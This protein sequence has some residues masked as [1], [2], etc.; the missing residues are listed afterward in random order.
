MKRKKLFGKLNNK[1]AGVVAVIVAIAL[2]S[3][4]ASVVLTTSYSNFKI[5]QTNYKSKTS[6]YS[7]ETALDEIAIGLQ[8]FVSE[9]LSYSYRE[10]I[11]NFNVLDSDQKQEKMESLYYSKLWEFLDPGNLNNHKKYDVSVL[12]GFLSEEYDTTNQVGAVVSSTNPEMITYDKKGI[13]LKNVDVYY[14]DKDDYSTFLSTDIRL[15]YPEVSFGVARDIPDI[16]SYAMVADTAV[17]FEGPSSGLTS[18]SKIIGQIYAGEMNTNV[19]TNKKV[20]LLFE[21]GNE[22]NEEFTVVS[23]N[24]INLVNSSVEFPADG[25]LW[26]KSIV[27]ASSEVTLRGTTNLSDDLE[28]RGNQSKAVVYGTYNGYGNSTEKADESSAIIINGKHSV[29]DFSNTDRVEL[30]GH[31][32]IGTSGRN[33]DESLDAKDVLTGESIAVKSDQLIY[34]VPSGAIGTNSSGEPVYGKNPMT[35]EEYLAMLGNAVITEVNFDYKLTEDGSIKLSDFVTTTGTNVADKVIKVFVPIKSNGESKN[36]VYYYI[37]FENDVKANEY[38][39]LLSDQDNAL[40]SK[41]T[42]RYADS[43][44]VADSESTKFS[45]GYYYDF[46][47]GKIAEVKAPLTGGSEH[48]HFD[49]NKENYSKKKQALCTKLVTNS[50]YLTEEELKN[51]LTNDVVFENLVDV[52]KVDSKLLNGVSKFYFKDD[53]GKNRVLFTNEAEYTY[54][55]TGIDKDLVIIISKGNVTVNNDF[56]GLILCDGTLT[57]KPNVNLTKDYVEVKADFALTAQIGVG[58][59]IEYVAPYSFMVDGK[60]LISGGVDP[61]GGVD[62]VKISELVTFENWEKE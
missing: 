52:T 9:A 45:A 40:L 26:T 20:N 27:L 48:N 8:G 21:S 24:D 19:D 30:A 32:F 55:N 35:A 54:S 42:S 53:E 33:S 16:M 50:S 18:E 7:A 34:L 25:I 3:I 15:S 5:K 38:F 41:Y 49:S 1:G 51:S 46:V 2:V 60:D 12:A 62:A 61:I 47:D 22:N 31:A 57:V 43:V 10:I 39:K 4:L 36:M 17:V 58:E 37:K 6:F 14:R 59:D 13:L 29:V 44:I 28:L 11:V 23:K 56:K